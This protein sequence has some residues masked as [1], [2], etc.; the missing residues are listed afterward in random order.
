MQSRKASTISV[1]SELSIIAAVEEA[2]EEAE[3]EEDEDDTVNL[4]AMQEETSKGKVKGNLLLRYISAG[5]NYVAVLIL[6]S[7]FLITQLIGSGVD[8]W[9]SYYV[10]V[11]EYRSGNITASDLENKPMPYRWSSEERLM[12]YG[13]GIVGLFIVAITRSVLFY[14]LAML[15]SISIHQMTFEN[16]IGATMRFFDTNPSGRIL[17]RFSKDMGSV[18]EALPKA[19][20]DSGQMMLSLLGAVVLVIIVNP[21]FIVLLIALSIVFG[22][23]RRVYLKTSKNVKRLEGM[24]K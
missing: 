11:E 24:S 13:A 19:I 7:L 16:V 9:V 10:N 14:K 23:L 15:S 5:T 2:L 20:L 22:F 1:V 18:D 17:N 21:H 8:Y 3:D 12:V 4:K 6:I